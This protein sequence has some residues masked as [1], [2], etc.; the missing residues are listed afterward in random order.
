VPGNFADAPGRTLN[1]AVTAIESRSPRRQHTSATAPQLG[2]VLAKTCYGARAQA[3]PG[4]AV[5]DPPREASFHPNVA[6]FY[7]HG[8]ETVEAVGGRGVPIQ[9]GHGSPFGGAILCENSFKSHNSQTCI[10]QQQPRIGN[11]GG[12]GRGDLLERPVGSP[13]IS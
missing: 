13:T 2:I 8:G 12:Q 11:N 3:T 5:I 9:N 10:I 4:I 7:F 1:A 6:G